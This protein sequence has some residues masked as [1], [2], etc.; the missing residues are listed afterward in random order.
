MTKEESVELAIRVYNN[1]SE[2]NVTSGLAHVTIPNAKNST[3]FVDHEER[4]RFLFLLRPFSACTLAFCPALPSF[5]LATA[6]AMLHAK[7][8]PQDA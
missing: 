1:S 3:F 7:P 4:T 2:S 8:R 5:S 6:I